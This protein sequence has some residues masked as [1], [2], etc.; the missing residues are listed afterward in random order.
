MRPTGSAE[1]WDSDHDRSIRATQN[2]SADSGHPT[3]ISIVATPDSMVSPVGGFFETFKSAGS[4]AAP[5]DRDGRRG[6]PFEVE[7]VS[8]RAGPVHGATG[9]TIEPSARSAR[10]TA[11]TSSSCRPW[12]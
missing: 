1:Q 11:P 2:V 10:S 7:I 12:F 6:E 3:R 9:L 5:E 4:M 8:E